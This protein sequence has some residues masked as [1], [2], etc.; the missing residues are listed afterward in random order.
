MFKKDNTP[1]ERKFT[2]TLYSE[3]KAIVVKTVN[4]LIKA[5]NMSVEQ[6]L[7]DIL[8]NWRNDESY[9]PLWSII[10]LGL[11]YSR[12]AINLLLDVFDS[13]ADIWAEAALEALER[14][15]E[16]HG[17]SVLDP[18]EQFIEERLGHDPYDSRLYAYGPIAVLTDSERSKRFLIRAMELDNVWCESIAYDLIRFGDKKVLSIF[19]RAIEYAHRDKDY[20]RE[21][22]LRDS[23]CLLAGV[24]QQNYDDN[25]LRKQP[26]EERW[27]D[28]LNELGKNDQE[29][30]KYYEN[31]FSAINKN[32]KDKE[33]IKEVEEHNSMRDNYTL[34][35]FSL[36][37]Y[38]KIRERG[39]VE[40][41]FQSALLI[42]GLSDLYS[43]E[44]VQKVIN[45]TTNPSEALNKILG[46][47]ELPSREGMNEFTI[48]FQ[49]LW[50]NTPREEFQGLMPIEISEIGLK[51]K[52]G[53]NDPCPCGATKSDGTSIKFKHCHGK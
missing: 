48:K 22:E 38:L 33:L 35:N 21:K 16:E 15:V 24:Y 42:S 3:D 17:E 31:K 50:N 49:N 29:I 41:D 7:L 44:D 43:V 32:F 8:K 2:T 27:S 45:S 5:K 30:D 37:E 13:D 51:R 20:D 40:Y 1:A 19:R 53:R 6:E 4:E 26:W 11:H 34:D 39:E 46:D 23:Y 18:I 14:I 47:Y 9:A 36:N 25:Y 28:K 52:I 10:I 12:S